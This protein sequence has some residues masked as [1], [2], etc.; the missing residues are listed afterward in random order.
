MAFYLV[1]SL[2]QLCAL[3]EIKM[4]CHHRENDSWTGAPGGAY[5]RI[6]N[7]ELRITNYE[8]RFTIYDL[9]FT[10]WILARYARFCE[11]KVKLNFRER[12]R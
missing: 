3:G 2:A 1:P 9:R 5:L 6:T 10:M 11:T 12:V 7:Y 4:Q 8:L